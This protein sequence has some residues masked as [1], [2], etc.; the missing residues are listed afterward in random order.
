MTI[1]VVIPARDAAPTIGRAVGSALAQ[2]PAP[3]W[4]IVVDDGSTDG[5]ADLA[6]AAGASVITLATPGGVAAARNAGVT[7]A[8]TEW[9]AFLDADDWWL[10]GHLALAGEQQRPGVV[11]VA[12]TALRVDAGG[13]V[14]GVSRP[15]PPRRG[16][17]DAILVG[18][19]LPTTSATIARAEA[20]LAAGAFD[21]RF[22]V[23]SCEDWDLW[24]RL[25]RRGEVAI[26]Q[27]PTAVYAV[28]DGARTADRLDGRAADR[29][30]S[31]A[32]RLADAAV[33][34][35]V[36]K[37]ARAWLEYDLA[38]TYLKYDRRGDARR[39]AVAAVGADWRR[40]RSWAILA[41]AVLPDPAQRMVRRAKRRL[42]RGGRTLEA[43]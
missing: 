12:G 16:A 5:T 34:P 6:R 22:S 1:A 27:Q 40:P 38:R 13:H 31:L 8:G 17:A 4:V 11:L 3:D 23:P 28:D 19:F 43:S 41:L 10:D 37:R 32:D 15:Q 18:E 20:V 39:R 25:A 14:V 35:A 33:P 21:E 30:R 7:A 29:R 9:V 26:V 24:V 36:A 42:A 2:R